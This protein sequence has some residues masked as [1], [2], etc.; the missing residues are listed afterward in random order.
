V[1]FA[2]TPPHIELAAV[3]RKDRFLPHTARA[4]LKLAESHFKNGH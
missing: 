4:F 2:K 3:Y 1:H